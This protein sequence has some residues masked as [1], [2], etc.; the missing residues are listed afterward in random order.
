MKQL[1][2]VC[3][4][5]AL[6]T[7]VSASQAPNDR[8]E[9]HLSP[10]KTVDLVIA[11]DVSGS[12][13][14]LIDS[15]KQ[16]LWDVV[17]ELGNAQPQPELRVALIS[18]GRSNYDAQRGYVQVDQS[19]T[20]NLDLLNQQLFSLTTNGGD[21][22]V[23]R[24]ISTSLDELQ[25]STGPDAVRI[26]F[27]AGNESAEQDPTMSLQKVTAA[28][29]DKGVVVNTLF[30]GS[31]DD[32]IAK[33]WM[34]AAQLG[35]GMYASIDQNAAAVAQIATPMDAKLVE[36]NQE[37]NGTYV[38]FGQEGERHRANQAAQDAN[39]AS[40]STQNVAS[41]TVAKASGLYRNAEWD[42]VDAADAGTDV[43]SLEAEALPAPMRDMSTDERRQYVAEKA[44]RRDELKKEIADLDRERSAIITAERKK[45]ADQSTVGLDDAIKT[46]LRKVATE[47]GLTFQS[48]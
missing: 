24:A 10:Q 22:Y 19:F 6:L 5:L 14:G 42:L 37:L 8:A 39:A 40:M 27:V 3:S 17:N 29:R 9:R 26:L 21:E 41:R 11:L 35:D 47:K 25:W 20:S 32:Q 16:R 1:L 45:Q 28:A 30:C 7:N 46:G 36:L 18:Y 44:Q 4:L 33:G 2:L 43:A 13:D 48:N 38:A 23:A 12:M 15:A 31:A 34:T